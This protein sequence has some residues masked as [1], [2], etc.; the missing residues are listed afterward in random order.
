MYCKSDKKLDEISNFRPFGPWL[1]MSC[2]QLIRDSKLDVLRLQSTWAMAWSP[3]LMALLLASATATAGAEQSGGLGNQS[4]F[5]ACCKAERQLCMYWWLVHL[6][7]HPASAIW[8]FPRICGHSRLPAQT[9]S[10][11]GWCSSFLYKLLLSRLMPSCTI[12]VL[13]LSNL[14]LQI[15]VYHVE[16]C[17]LLT[18]TV[19]LALREVQ[20][21][22][23][24]WRQAVRIWQREQLED[25]VRQFLQNFWKYECDFWMSAIESEIIASVHYYV[26]WKISPTNVL[27]P[28]LVTSV[29]RTCREI[30]RMSG[31]P[32]ASRSVAVSVRMR[33]A[34]FSAWKKLRWPK[35]LSIPENF[36][37]MVQRPIPV[38]FKCPISMSIM[39]QPVVWNG[40]T[41]DW[42]SLE[43][44]TLAQRRPSIKDPLQG[45]VVSLVTKINDTPLLQ[46]LCSQIWPWEVWGLCAARNCQER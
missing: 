41:Y 44:M 40:H 14:H 28:F 35:P 34:G 11:L 9:G 10:I 46:V 17:L 6:Q 8:H 24:A 13:F 22:G 38:E 19:L 2:S 20:L 26:V 18:S 23:H 32:V 7:H 27:T 15:D 33:Q 25:A 37:E 45:V 5:L 39:R 1:Y 43:Q 30:L 16:S 29:V 3:A 12:W 31:S 21:L 36:E 4:S 42:R